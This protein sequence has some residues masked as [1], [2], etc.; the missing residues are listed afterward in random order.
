MAI[1]KIGKE[2]QRLGVPHHI[3]SRDKQDLLEIEGK[4]R[5]T[6]DILAR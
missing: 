2:K 6:H 3:E 5:C 1:E 4:S